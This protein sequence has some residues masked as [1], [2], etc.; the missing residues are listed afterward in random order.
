MWKQLSLVVQHQS[1][2]GLYSKPLALTDTQLMQPLL[3]ARGVCVSMHECFYA[4]ATTWE[5]PPQTSRVLTIFQLL[6]ADGIGS[7]GTPMRRS[8]RAHCALVWGPRRMTQRDAVE[9]EGRKAAQFAL[10]ACE[11]PPPPRDQ[12]MQ[13]CVTTAS[14]VWELPPPLA[15][16][17]ESLPS[18]PP[19]VALS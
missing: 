3:C 15:S 13:L 16:A 18:T 6:L 10:A 1:V 2:A 7:D 11:P 14:Q 8:Q 4:S 12:L 17:N 9:E 5:R 19:R